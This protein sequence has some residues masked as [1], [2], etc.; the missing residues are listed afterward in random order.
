MDSTASFVRL[1][2]RHQAEVE[3]YVLTMLP[4]ATAAAEVLQEVSVRL[5]E[6]SGF[7][8]REIDLPQVYDAFSPYVYIWLESLGFCPEGEA[9]RFVM[10]GNIDSDRPGSL[11]VVSGGGALG[12]GR[13]H[14]VP[15]LLECYLQLSGRAEARQRAANTALFSY[16][17]P[18]F[19]GSFVLTNDAS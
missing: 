2:T 4:Y 18:N 14:G 11:A 12:N 5:W 1:W 7:S 16:S 15:Q 13:L 3:R 17:A 10:D 19:G 9:H 8:P 6:K